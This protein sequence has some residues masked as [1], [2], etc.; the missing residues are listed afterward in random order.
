MKISNLSNIELNSETFFKFWKLVHFRLYITARQINYLS[1]QFVSTLKLRRD[2]QD[3]INTIISGSSLIIYESCD[4][5]KLKWYWITVFCELTNI[6]NLTSFYL[7][8]L[9]NL[10]HLNTCVAKLFS[11]RWHSLDKN[12]HISFSYSLTFL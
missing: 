2:L 8:N 9:C 6:V 1:Q 7:S 10:I 3:N 12:E 4:I 5:S 11:V